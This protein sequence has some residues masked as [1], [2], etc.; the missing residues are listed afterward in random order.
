MHNGNR[1][2][3]SKGALILNFLILV[4]LNLEFN[5]VLTYF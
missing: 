4:G 2:G 3:V 5:I 1:I